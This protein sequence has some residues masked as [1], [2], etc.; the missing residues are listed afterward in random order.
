MRT[1]EKIISIHKREINSVNAAFAEFMSLSESE[2]N[3]R[4]TNNP[5]LYK[6]LS[7]SKLEEVT[8]DLLRDVA[9]RT[10]F[11]PEDITLVAGH[12]FPDIMATD[13]CGV[14]VKS[15]KDDKWTSIG[16]SIVE[17]TRNI[18]VENIY[19]LFGKLGGDLPEF[20]LRP[21]QDCLSDIAVTHSPRY[22]INMELAENET[23]FDKMGTTYDELRTSPEAIDRVRRYYRNKA[24]EENKLEMPWW[25]TA[26]NIESSQPFNITLWNTLPDIVKDDLQTKC[27]ILFPEALNPARS[28]TKYNQT[29]LWLCSYNQVIVPN[30]RDFYSAGGKIT[31]VNGK[32]IRPNAPQVFARIV[33]FADMIKKAL[34]DPTREMIM[35]IRDYNPQLLRGG[36]LY[37]NWLR[38][39]LQYA[40]KE[41][42]PLEEWIEEK[43]IFT[44]SNNI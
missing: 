12:R 9:P 37:Q 4:S 21:Y 43:P 30:I 8:R 25:I 44:F 16:S 39:C 42:V 19:M 22:L 24:K 20:R 18:T 34:N 33:K 2:F 1:D 3:L 13:Y 14:E 6:G 38:I 27:M 41:K 7:P 26:D 31:H 15:T 23:I 29:T 32:S 28:Q 5:K 11:K 40:E 17:S 35:L 10:P 36:N